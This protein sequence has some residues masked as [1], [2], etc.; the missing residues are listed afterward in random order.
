M[1]GYDLMDEETRRRLKNE[2]NNAKNVL[3]VNLS[4]EDLTR[5][6]DPPLRT[7]ANALMEQLKGELEAAAKATRRAAFKGF[8]VL[9]GLLTAA[10][11]AMLIFFGAG[12]WVAVSILQAMGTL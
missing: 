5:L 11:L 2:L 6:C 4:P 12:I 9:G 3:G 8:L 10:A 7:D 1:N